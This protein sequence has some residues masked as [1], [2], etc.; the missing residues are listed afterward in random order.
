MSES[1]DRNLAN[2]AITP[3]I[4]EG[5]EVMFLLGDALG[6]IDRRMSEIFPD[7][8]PNEAIDKYCRQ[9]SQGADVSSREYSIQLAVLGRNMAVAAK[10]GKPFLDYVGAETLGDY[11]KILDPRG[12]KHGSIY[13]YKLS[14]E[15]WPDRTLLE[16]VEAGSEYLTAA[17]RVAKLM[18]TQ[19]EKEKIFDMVAE[20]PTVKALVSTLESRTGPGFATCASLTLTGDAEE[21]ATIAALCHQLRGK[22]PEEG[23]KDPR[24][25]VVLASLMAFSAEEATDI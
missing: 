11:E 9:A 12:G 2:A 7:D 18:P 15:L 20:A 14:C 23:R 3:L 24:T 17:S 22:V 4:H 25:G 6:N 16:I 1:F 21:I 10:R 13:K 8:M 19:E 5:S